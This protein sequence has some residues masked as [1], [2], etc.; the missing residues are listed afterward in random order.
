MDNEDADECGFSVL[1]ASIRVDP[2]P[3]LLQLAW[4]AGE[5]NATALD[6]MPGVNADQHGG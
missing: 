5:P 4:Q 3:L 6:L 2:R 1:S